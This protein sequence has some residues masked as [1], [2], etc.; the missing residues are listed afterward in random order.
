MSTANSEKNQSQQNEDGQIE[1][2]L[3]FRPFS[4]GDDQGF[5]Q[6]LQFFVFFVFHA[7]QHRKKPSPLR[8]GPCRSTPI[9]TFS[10]IAR[11]LCISF[12]ALTQSLMS[13]SC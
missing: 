7:L 11:I 1:P 5:N 3:G 9:Y 6:L 13:S 4:Q 8:R 10:C 12:N 2:R